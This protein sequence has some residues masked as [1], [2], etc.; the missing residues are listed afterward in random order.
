MWTEVCHVKLDTQEH[1][2]MSE[3]A[4]TSYLKIG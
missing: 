3:Q 4:V 1:L 2:G